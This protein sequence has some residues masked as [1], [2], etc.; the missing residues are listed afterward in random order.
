MNSNKQQQQY[1]RICPLE[2]FDSFSFELNLF[3]LHR[4]SGKHGIP[5]NENPNEI[6]FAEFVE[7]KAKLQKMA[8]QNIDFVICVIPR[9]DPG[10]MYH[11]IKITADLNVGITTQCIKSN[12]LTK[13]TQ[14][15]REQFLLQLNAKLNGVNQKLSTAPILKDF[16]TEPIMFIGAHVA[17]PVPTV[18]GQKFA[19][20]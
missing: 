13:D 20:W 2:M 15:W 12:T 5:L 1:K 19:P 3:Q 14:C 8:E 16:D 9:D 10:L 7:I 4:K 17:V 18:P 6:A 11:E